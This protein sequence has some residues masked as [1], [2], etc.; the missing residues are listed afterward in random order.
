MR[1][2]LLTS[3]QAAAQNKTI[4]C[5]GARIKVA[6]VTARFRNRRRTTNKL[7]RPESAIS[8]WRENVCYQV[9]LHQL[10]LL[11][12]FFRR[13]FTASAA[14]FRQTDGDRLLAAFYSLAGT[15]AFQLSTFTLMH[16][17]F[18]FSRCGFAVSCHQITPTRYFLASI[19]LRSFVKIRSNLYAI[20]SRS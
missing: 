18:D 5:R 1:R 17:P 12:R 14:R 11:A 15:T 16:R 2:W 19:R 13:D 20:E 10:L 4:K 8:A 9:G 3:T 7:I 6:G